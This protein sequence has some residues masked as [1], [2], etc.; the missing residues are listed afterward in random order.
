MTAKEALIRSTQALLWERG[1]VGT[2][3]KAI[4]LKAGAGQGSMYHHFEGKA[5]LAFTAIERSAE[6]LRLQIEKSLSV[7]GS[8]YE[9]ISGFLLRQRDV[10]RGCRVGRLAQDPEVVSDCRLRQPIADIFEMLQRRLGEVLELGVARKEF[11]GPIDTRKTAAA[12]A[13]VLQG[14]YVLARA[15][16]STK[17]F[18]DAIEGLLALL[19]AQCVA[20]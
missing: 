5:D 7:E 2:S 11:R 12:I 15:G 18:S 9:R 10:L 17:P 4:L 3:P 8:A 13:A 1:Y 14:G 19:P 20:R 6:E 16:N